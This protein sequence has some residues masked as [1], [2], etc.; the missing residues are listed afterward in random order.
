MMKNKIPYIALITAVTLMQSCSIHKNNKEA[1]L[2]LDKLENKYIVTDNSVNKSIAYE[3]YFQ[4]AVLIDLIHK[5]LSNNNDLISATNQLQAN[6]AVLKATKLNYLPDVNLHIN[7]SIQRLSKNS[8]IGGFADD[9]TY[10]DHTIS[11]NLTWELDLWGKLKAERTEA[12]ALYLSQA[13]NIRAIKIQ[14]IAQTATV[15]YNLV[16]LANQHNELQNLKNI[17]TNSV[18]MLQQQYKFGDASSI[19]VKQ[20]ND[21]V[22]DLENTLIEVNQTIKN[23]EIVLSSL[24][25]KY[26]EEYT[27]NADI[28]KHNFSYSKDAKISIAQLQNRPD[29]K[30]AELQLKAANA[31]VGITN[32]ALYP[33]I[34]LSAQGGLNSI[35]AS[36]IFDVPASLFGNLAGS[37]TQPLLN[38]RR[39]KSN[40][41]QAKFTRDASIATFKQEVIKSVGEVNEAMNNVDFLDQKK[42]IAALK[43]SNLADGMDDAQKLFQFGEITYLEVLALQQIYIQANINNLDINRKA[44]DAYINLFKAIGG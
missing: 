19:A 18:Q 7:P 11:A 33:S 32:A 31:R 43:V 6:Q 16:F 13:E 20:A 17:A 8:M 9:L 38:K 36:N 2:A 44:I 10:E 40:L 28:S 23:Q 42:N 25:G 37:I 27:F 26:P 14:L 1:D 22:L 39:L 4:D 34:V 29:V 21:Q 12:K 30:K 3:T 5:V 41:E 24:L 35:T 15:Y